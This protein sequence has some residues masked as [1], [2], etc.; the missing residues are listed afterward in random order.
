MGDQSWRGY[1]RGV[2]PDLIIE[3]PY[4]GFEDDENCAFVW[5]D[6]VFRQRIIRQRVYTCS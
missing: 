2:F 6:R 5:M 1:R 4:L 3:S